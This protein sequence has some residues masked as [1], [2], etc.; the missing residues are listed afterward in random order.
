LRL[1]LKKGNQKK[2]GIKRVC[3]EER[4]RKLKKEKM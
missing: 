1:A 3:V 2:K 4:K